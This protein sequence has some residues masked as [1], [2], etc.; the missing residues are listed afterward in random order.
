[1][2]HAVTFAACVFAAA[3][4]PRAAVDSQSSA[5]PCAGA[6]AGTVS[7]ARAWARPAAAGQ[8]SALYLT[9]CNRGADAD[10]LL[11]VQSPLA[12][13]LEI[14]ETTRSDAGV[15]RMNPAARIAVP[16]NA[17][18]LLAPGGLHVMLI[19]LEESI[20]AGEEVG[21]TLVFEKSGELA[22]KATVRRDAAETTHD[23]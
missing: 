13:S 21:F 14:H 11:R 16:A 22:A 23:H 10:A 9:I 18:M 3:C 1:M 8:T 2:R 19:G 12:R 5:E 20:E 4:A 7:V 6:P 17:A 15:A